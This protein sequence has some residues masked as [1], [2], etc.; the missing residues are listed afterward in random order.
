MARVK[1]PAQGFSGT[2]FGVRFRNGV[3]E[4]DDERAL[5]WFRQHGYE[6]EGA[7]D[8]PLDRHTVDEL[9]AMA[10]DLDIEGRSDMKKAELVTAIAAARE[11]E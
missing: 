11:A 4:T 2:R 9:Q 7:G 10:A 8:K 1:A 3:G 5:H 6:V